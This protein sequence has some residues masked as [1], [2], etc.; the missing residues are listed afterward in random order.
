MM[1]DCEELGGAD[2]VAMRLEDLAKAQEIKDS[3]SAQ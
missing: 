1:K 2:I 3:L